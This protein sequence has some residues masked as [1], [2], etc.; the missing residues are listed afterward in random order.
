MHLCRALNRPLGPQVFVSPPGEQ[1][2][3]RQD[4]DAFKYGVQS[5]EDYVLRQ[6]MR[7]D[8]VN[9]P[10]LAQS[11]LDGYRGVRRPRAVLAIPTSQGVPAHW[12][13]G[14]IRV[15]DVG[16]SVS[17]GHVFLDAWVRPMRGMPAFMVAVLPAAPQA[18]L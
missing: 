5:A 2:F 7:T 18:A 13:H 3:S 12:E 6:L 15:M 8:V 4:S 17:K 11:V 16:V 1:R 9:L 14:W 10:E